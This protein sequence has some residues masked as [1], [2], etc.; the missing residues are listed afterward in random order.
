MQ[1][2]VTR[3]QL[4]AGVGKFGFGPADAQQIVAALETEGRIEL[5]G[6]MLHIKN[7][8]D[9]DAQSLAGLC[10]EARGAT[11]GAV[12]T[13]KIREYLQ[14]ALKNASKHGSSRRV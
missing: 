11:S 1:F 3:Y 10:R 7:P 8:T 2:P 12:G 13:Y 14:I 6:S 9:P 5:S 4:I